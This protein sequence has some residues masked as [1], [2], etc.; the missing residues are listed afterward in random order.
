MIKASF[1]KAWVE[2]M[3][4]HLEIKEE[5]QQDFGVTYTEALGR[6]GHIEEN[7][8]RGLERGD[9]YEQDRRLLTFLWKMMKMFCASKV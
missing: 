5:K 3:V 6:C 9:V 2:R 8:Q 7:L 4:S 1:V